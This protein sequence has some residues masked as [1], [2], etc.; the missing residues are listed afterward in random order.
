[1]H[2]QVSYMNKL[3]T[4]QLQNQMNYGTYLEKLHTIILINMITSCKTDMKIMILEN[5]THFLYEIGR[6]LNELKLCFN[7]ST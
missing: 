2:Y 3:N 6:T 7:N 1:M 4:I 5:V